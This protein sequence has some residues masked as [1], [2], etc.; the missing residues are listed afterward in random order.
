M[1][2]L[3]EWVRRLVTLVVVFSFLEL[4][5]P[6]NSLKR[7]V[8]LVV[9]F[10]ILTTVLG[11]LVALVRGDEALRRAAGGILDEALPRLPEGP[12][13]AS[14]LLETNRR[15]QNALLAERLAAY[16]QSELE[17]SAKVRVGVA[18]RVDG[19]GSVT[20]INLAVPEGW[21]ERLRGQAAALAG[22]EPERI[23]VLEEAIP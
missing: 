23:A 8:R 10:L 5:A 1:A 17:T 9:G 13:A 14:R 16:L 21:G 11:P 2:E 7:Y 3:T 18:V 12:D 6:P 19:A 15:L 20:R 4:L 22:V